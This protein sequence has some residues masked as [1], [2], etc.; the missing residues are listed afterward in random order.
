[1]IEKTYSGVIMHAVLGI[2]IYDVFRTMKKLLRVTRVS[3]IP[4][5]RILWGR[6]VGHGGFDSRTVC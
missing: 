2:Y 6:G 4:F 3:E 5:V 1:M